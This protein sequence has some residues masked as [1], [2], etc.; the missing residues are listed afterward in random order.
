MSD[1]GLTLFN[2]EA[3]DRALEHVSHADCLADVEDGPE[4]LAE[5]RDGL[6]ELREDLEEAFPDATL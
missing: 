2:L 5:Y 1:P 4:R 3:A 6:D